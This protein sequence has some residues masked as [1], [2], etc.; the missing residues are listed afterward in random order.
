MACLLPPYSLE[1][2]SSKNFGMIFLLARS[3]TKLE[4]ELSPRKCAREQRGCQLE[5][6]ADALDERAATALEF[7][8]D[9]QALRL[10][11]LVVGNALHKLN[12]QAKLARDLGQDPVVLPDPVL[13]PHLRRG[14]LALLALRGLR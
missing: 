5:T 13:D 1:S 4:G 14:E 9:A 8:L 2:F 6:L 11:F 10:R 12:R 7:V 3:V